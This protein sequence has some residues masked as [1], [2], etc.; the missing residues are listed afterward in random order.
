MCLQAARKAGTNTGTSEVP[1]PRYIKSTSTTSDAGDQDP[2]SRAVRRQGLQ[3][4]VRGSSPPPLS[5]MN[6]QAFVRGSSPP[7]FSAIN[8]QAIP[9]EGAALLAASQAL[10]KYFH[11]S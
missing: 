6:L 9:E 2:L 11:T 1:T 7:P 8:L 3:A 10:E 5:A 4:S